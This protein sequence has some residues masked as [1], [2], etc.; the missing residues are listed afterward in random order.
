M[1]GFLRDGGLKRH[2]RRIIP[3]YRERRDALLQALQTYMPEP[4]RWTIPAGGFC[5]WLTW[6]RYDTPGELYRT[7]LERGF[8]ITPGE[9]FLL[10]PGP[11]EHIRLCFG[12]QTTEGI[13]AGVELLGE[14]IT[15]QI[16][17]SQAQDDQTFYWLPPV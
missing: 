15:E 13:R 3:P 2:L 12:N 5:C 14:L 7:A 1:A 9:A 10:E 16:Q 8:A 6:P 17:K 4:V 11:H